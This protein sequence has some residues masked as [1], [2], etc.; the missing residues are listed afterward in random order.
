MN[1]SASSHF[2]GG[3]ARFDTRDE[4]SCG[5]LLLHGDFVNAFLMP[6]ALKGCVEEHLD[7]LNGL[8][9]GNKTSRHGK[10]VGI[11]VPTCKTGHIG[12]PAQSRAYALM[13]VERDVDALTA[14]TH[15]DAGIAL[16]RLDCYCTRVGKVGIVT[17]LF[18]IG[19]EVLIG[20]A[21]AVEPRLNGLFGGISGVVATQCHGYAG[22]QD[23]HVGFYF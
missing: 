19:A 9:V 23:V 3:R 10:Y 2:V 14:A 11:V 21:V 17:T 7:H 16:A 1:S 5:Y 18:V 8:L 13:L 12:Y 6:T 4:A 22:F 20:Y 15:R